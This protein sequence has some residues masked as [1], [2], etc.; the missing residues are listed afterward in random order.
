MMRWFRRIL[1]GGLIVGLVFGSHY[2]VQHNKEPVTLDL[3]AI[4][5]EAVPLWLV[6]LWSFVAGFGVA[7]A[8]ALWRGARLRLESRRYRKAAH[9]LEAEVHQLRTLPL[10]SAD[11][12][13]AAVQDD[14]A[15]DGLSRGT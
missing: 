1:W 7:A 10:A 2:Y 5:F 15:G 3:L 4:R 8:V 6:T 9:S 11:A 12:G 14:T 13:G